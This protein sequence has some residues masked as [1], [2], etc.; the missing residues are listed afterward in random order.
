MMENSEDLSNQTLQEFALADKQ[1]GGLGW[2]N[3]VLALPLKHLTNHYLS[4]SPHELNTPI[5]F[6]ANQLDEMVSTI[7]E[8]VSISRYRRL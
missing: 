6:E 8:E 5:W 2:A 1:N 4:M 3:A 7:F